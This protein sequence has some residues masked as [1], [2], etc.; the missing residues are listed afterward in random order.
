MTLQL[1][2]LRHIGYRLWGKDDRSVMS[3]IH[4]IAHR[5]GKLD[6]GS[7]SLPLEVVMVLFHHSRTD[8]YIPILTLN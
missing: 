5:G 7:S 8:K 2:T 4:P 6:A 1:P 3:S